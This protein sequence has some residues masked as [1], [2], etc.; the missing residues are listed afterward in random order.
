M[1]TDNTVDLHI[2]KIPRPEFLSFDCNPSRLADLHSNEG[3]CCM[4]TKHTYEFLAKA[5][6]ST[7]CGVGGFGVASSFW[8]T[9][10]EC[11]VDLESLHHGQWSRKGTYLIGLDKSRPTPFEWDL[12]PFVAEG[13]R[14]RTK[15][16]YDFIDNSWGRIQF[17]EIPV[18]QI[19]DQ[20]GCEAA[21]GCWY[22][23]ACHI[24]PP[25][26]HQLNDQGDCDRYGCYWALE[27]CRPMPVRCDDW[28]T[29]QDCINAGCEWWGSDNP[30]LPNTCHKIG[31]KVVTLNIDP[32][33][34]ADIHSNELPGTTNKVTFDIGKNIEVCGGI[35][36]VMLRKGGEAGLVSC[37]FWSLPF[38]SEMVRNR[39]QVRLGSPKNF[40]EDFSINEEF[41]RYGSALRV[42][43]SFSDITVDVLDMMLLYKDVVCEEITTGSVCYLMGC[44]WYDGG[45]HSEPQ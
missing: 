5:G 43:T 36:T 38:G 9:G 24:M 45:C 21:G 20:Q 41:R 31:L 14:L 4:I 23:G 30:Y 44:Y 33:Q 12:Y 2:A 27:Q 3:C 17:G 13:V 15:K 10:E 18:T 37:C 32:D 16:S 7:I 29:E 19:A 1:T 6:E 40:N 42:G 8:P 39:V 35:G 11:E 22:N 28:V 34:P 26:C 25:L